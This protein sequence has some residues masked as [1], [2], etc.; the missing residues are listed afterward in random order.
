MLRPL[1]LV[2]LLATSSL[3]SHDYKTWMVRYDYTEA[4]CEGA[5]DVA[6]TAQIR[7][8]ASRSSGT[9]YNAAVDRVMEDGTPRKLRAGASPRELGWCDLHCRCQTI[10]MCKIGNYCSDSCTTCGCDRRMEEEPSFL[11]PQQDVEISIPLEDVGEEIMAR[12]EGGI[13][14]LGDEDGVEDCST[15]DSMRGRKLTQQEEEKIMTCTARK[16]L[17]QLARNLKEEGCNCLG[18]PERLEVSVHID[19]G[20]T[21]ADDRETVDI[22]TAEDYVILTKSGISTVPDSNITGD[23]GVS[24]IAA[25]ALTGFSLSEDSTT[26]FSTSSQLTGQ[27]FAASYGAPTSTRLTAAV[28]HMEVAYTD[29]ASRQV[30]EDRVNFGAGILGGEYGGPAN[31]LTAGV[32]TFRVDVTITT[33]ITFHGDVFDIFIIQMTGNL[34]QAA[35]K[36]VILTGGA[37][38]KNIFWQV[39]GYVEVGAGAHLEGI[40]LAKTKVDFLTGSSLTGRI[41]AQT[42]CNLQKATITA[43]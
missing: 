41:L 35:N 37:L 5:A 31:P 28:S 3:A 42:A 2:L 6:I 36:K 40:L 43:P 10:L 32:Y 15:W 13:R 30:N 11:W 26:Q 22:G 34:I 38:A 24:P 1:G 17:K 29:A 33:D 39:A 25:A 27:A 20:E 21:S 14:Q 23:I 8:S 9:V 18:D 12:E 16:D 7:Q 19:S 4:D